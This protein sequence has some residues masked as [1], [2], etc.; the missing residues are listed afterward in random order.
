MHKLHITDKGLLIPSDCLMG[1]PSDMVVR[2][3]NNRL[4]IE[5]ESQA[6]TNKYLADTVEKLHQAGDDLG[7]PD[8]NEIR[9]L[10][11]EVRLNNARHH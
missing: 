9:K 8:E 3:V 6:L 10:V 2:R 4:F 1:L 11:D 5:T 7:C